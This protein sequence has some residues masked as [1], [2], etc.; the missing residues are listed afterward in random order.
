MKNNSTNLSLAVAI[1]CLIV[2]CC[3][4]VFIAGALFFVS[5]R[6]EV[7]RLFN[8][9]QSQ[10]E[11]TPVVIRPTPLPVGPTASA[12]QDPTVVPLP[13]TLVATET[14]FTLQNSD[15]PEADLIEL[16]KRFQGIRDIQLT[17]TAPAVALQIEDQEKF[18]LID[19]DVN[20]MFQVSAKL[21]YIGEHVY[22]WVEDGVD[23]DQSAMQD[24]IQTFDEQIYPTNREFFGSEWTPGIDNDPRIYILYARNMGHNIA[25]YFSSS[26]E[27][28]LQAHKYS[29]AHEMFDVNADV[30]RLGEKFIKNVLA[31]EFQH[32]IHWYRDRNEETWISEGFSELAALLNGFYDSG[33][34]ILFSADPDIQLNTWPDSADGNST[35]HYGA[36]FLFMSY[37]LDRF[38]ES[39]TKAVVAEPENGLPS[40]DRAFATLN[41]RDPLT[42]QR[43]TVDDFFL[44]W[45]IT[46]YINDAQVGDGRYVYKRYTTVPEFSPTQ[47]FRECPINPQ[48]TSVHQYAADYIRFTC[49]GDYHLN[50]EGSIQTEVVPTS[51]KSGDYMLW[52]N[53]NDES[54]MTL[55][56]TFDFSAQT[57][58]LTLDYWTW[59]D[60]EDGYDFTYLTASEDGESWT[61]LKTPSGTDTNP[62]GSN[63]GWGYTGKSGAGN[64][65]TWIHEV[66]DLS[67][68]AG[69]RIQLR[70]EYITDAAVNRNGFLLDDLSIP[71]IGY[72]TDFESDN[73]GWNAAG[74]SRINNILPQTW[75][76]ALI[77]S[78]AQ[79]TS[80]EYL[81]L[82]P[83]LSLDVPLKFGGDVESITLV[84]SATT[85]FTTQ[86]ASYRY[87]LE[88]K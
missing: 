69:K 41:I 81:V 78:G 76:L 64:K 40:F 62:S 86:P 85:Q 45:V 44:D 72:T 77:R 7:T 26:D 21:K 47:E 43:M 17:A 53:R 13:V 83:D 25:G 56:H 75:Q 58:S 31:H 5:M 34:D 87:W 29:N 52:T 65:P 14:L 39:A 59:Y 9:P 10:V 19:K 71:E 35:P 68:Y 15:A 38:G 12:T 60:I 46:N 84:V 57:G 70:F 11:Y 51:P 79:T 42:Q 73:G 54:D 48:V 20:Q 32:M 24:L 33:F 36:S 4:V 30:V 67:M 50:F 27:L 23:F 22:F 37:F 88:K 82:K 1:G 66:V 80:V 6:Q 55:T 28:P 61:T 16:A 2:A 8:R 49:A 74:W 18:W 3:M 63:Y